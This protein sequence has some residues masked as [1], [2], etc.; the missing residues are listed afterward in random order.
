[1]KTGV[2]GTGAVGKIIATKLIS[3][4]HE[5][6]MGSRT[7]NNEKALQWVK[8]SGAKA[9]TGT[10]SDVAQFA[11]VIFNCTKGEAALQVLQLAGK[12]ALKGKLIIDV[13]NPLDFSKGFPPTLTVCNTD[14]VG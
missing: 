7:N 9:S 2:F 13:S 1:M 14:S 8:N 4:G 10:F 11:D 5:V 12:D 3:L 6:K